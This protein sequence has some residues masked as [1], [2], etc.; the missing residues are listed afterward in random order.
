MSSD[1]TSGS[2]LRLS[3]SFSTLSTSGK[4]RI[5]P[6][7]TEEDSILYDETGGGWSTVDQEERTTAANKA[8][9]LAQELIELRFD[10]RDAQ[11]AVHALVSSNVGLG[12]SEALDWLC[13]HVPEDRLP[14]NF[15]PGKFK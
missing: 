15:A 2:S 6:T 13:L 8:D 14:K 1:I 9:L 10:A 4:E 7:S 12:L 3:S 11:A 5:P